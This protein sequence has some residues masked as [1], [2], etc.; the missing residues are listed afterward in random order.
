MPSGDVA[1]AALAAAALVLA[2]CGENKGDQRRYSYWDPNEA[3][4]VEVETDRNAGPTPTSK[5]VVRLFVRAPADATVFPDPIRLGGFT[6]RWAPGA[7]AWIAPDTVN[8]CPLNRDPSTPKSVAVKPLP[9][10][11]T[12]IRITTDCDNAPAIVRR[13]GR[14]ITPG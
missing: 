7:I 3:F 4:L 5:N 8:V 1:R 10:A 13:P 11:P 14:K 2:G 6:G 12:V 9:G